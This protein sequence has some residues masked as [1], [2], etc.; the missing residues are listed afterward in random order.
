MDDATTQITA[1]A[2][3][4]TNQSGMR[5]QNERLVL[6]LLRRQGAMPKAEIARATG[7]SAQTVSVIMRALEA[8]GLLLKGERQRGRVGQPSV[9]M[10]LNPDGVF[11]LGLKVGRR[12]IE[13]IL[14]DFLG[15][16]R[17][18]RKQVHRYPDFEDV[19]NFATR[20]AKEL[21][22]GIDPT[23]MG[24]IGIALPNH[25]W[26]WATRLGV[27]PSAMEAW[28]HRD[29]AQ[30]LA[31]ATGLAIYRQNDATSACSAELVFGQETLPAHFL[32]LFV[33]FFIGGGLVFNRALFSGGSGNAAGMGTLLVPDR[34]G[35]MRPLIDHASLVQLEARMRDRGLDEM[36]L[37][38][39]PANWAIPADVL[40]PWLEETAFALAG[41]IHA[42]QAILDLD[43]VLIDGWMPAALRESLVTRVAQEFGR[44]DQT[45]IS[46]P[47]IRQ[48]SIGPD[49]RA[50]GA[51]SLPLSDRW[52]S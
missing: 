19:L 24:G 30:E 34:A 37:W 35:Q 49:A 27:D 39:S 11:F 22:D 52:L 51:A 29:L 46:P 5:A 42:S 21:R 13:M 28:A 26:S 41:A 20:S 8:D 1:P 36:A 31:E 47:D 18:R 43:A 48:G 14:T 6:T 23:R 7:L 45:G 12:S 40:E 9:P 44:I 15:A 33:A 17:A 38:E 2:H 25:L 10:A 3:P 50:F 16:I 32:H 4:G